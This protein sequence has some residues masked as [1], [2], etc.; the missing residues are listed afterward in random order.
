MRTKSSPFNAANS[1]ITLL[2]TANIPASYTY[3]I[4]ETPAEK[5]MNWVRGA[6]TAVSFVEGLKSSSQVLT[7][8]VGGL[9]LAGAKLLA[10]LPKALL[11][12]F[13]LLAV[14]RK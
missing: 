14:P 4:L 10:D 8:L 3:G 7:W 5:V 13:W 11:W 1:K 2:C 6:Q 9:M 12:P